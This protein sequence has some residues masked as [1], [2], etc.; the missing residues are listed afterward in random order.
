MS[1][2][3]S[4][5][6]RSSR[7]GPARR[8]EEPG[9]IWPSPQPGG[10]KRFVGHSCRTGQEELQLSPETCARVKLRGVASICVCHLLI[11]IVLLPP[12][13]FGCLLFLFMCLIAVARTSSTMWN[14]SGKA[15]IRVLCLILRGRLLVFAC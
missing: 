6:A 13:Q 14:R 4:L 2:G 8:R 3:H 9:G 11:M 7:R 10:A 1:P 5:T 15:D 12:F